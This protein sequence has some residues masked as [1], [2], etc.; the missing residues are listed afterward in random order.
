MLVPDTLRRNGTRF[1]IERPQSRS[2]HCVPMN[3]ALASEGP[4][5]GNYFWTG[6]VRTKAGIFEPDRACPEQGKRPKRNEKQTHAHHGREAES[7]E[8]EG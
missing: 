2:K 1:V 6:V 7:Y 4:C 8:R 3:E 5:I